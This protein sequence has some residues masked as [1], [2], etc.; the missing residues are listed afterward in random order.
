MHRIVYIRPM[1]LPKQKV[2][3]T[4]VSIAVMIPSFLPLIVQNFPMHLCPKHPDAYCLSCLSASAL[5]RRSAIVPFY[6]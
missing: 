5:K 1:L 4:Y 3:E 6:N 2:E